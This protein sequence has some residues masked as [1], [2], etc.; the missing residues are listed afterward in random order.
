MI[1]MEDIVLCTLQLEERFPEFSLLCEPRKAVL[2]SMSFQM[3]INGL[4]GFKKMLAAVKGGDWATAYAEGLNSRWCEQTPDR[5]MRQMTTM[6]VGNW[7]QY[8]G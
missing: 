6:L 5:A 7:S 3:G 1:L 8:E 4:M 2:V